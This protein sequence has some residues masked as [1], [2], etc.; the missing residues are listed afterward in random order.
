MS[1]STPVV[2]YIAGYGRSGST[3][4]NRLLGQVPGVCGAGELVHVRGWIEA[5]R[6]CACGEPI[7]ACPFWSRVRAALPAATPA[8]RAW[9]ARIESPFALCFGFWWVPARARERYRVEQRALFAAIAAADAAS[10]VVDC[11]KSAA[12]VAARARA[13]EEI[14][15]LDLRLVH[16]SRSP[17]AVR[18]SLMRGTNRELEGRVARG[19]RLRRLRAFLGWSLA[20]RCAFRLSRGKRPGSTCRVRFEDLVRDPAGTLRDLALVLSLPPAALAAAAGADTET[21]RHVAEG[22]RMRMQP[23]SIAPEDVPESSR[24][25]RLMCVLT[26]GLASRRL[27]YTATGLAPIHGRA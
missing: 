3:L 9:F 19:R 10:V 16:L 15:G 18:A 22:N 23:L 1:D 20:N 24:A 12:R 8:E 25:D 17:Q 6:P 13:L 5:A 2:A 11:S 26:C 14:A 4:L 27:G 7:A 21:F